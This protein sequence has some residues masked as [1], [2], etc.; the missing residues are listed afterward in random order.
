MTENNQKKFPK[1]DSLDRLI[2]FFDEN[3]LGDY[4]EQMPETD[5][6]V[7][8]QKRSYFVALDAEIADK[9]SEISKLEHLSS[10]K[11]VNSWLREKISSYSEKI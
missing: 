7:N 10:E 8:L 5:F 3:D 6:E 4:L 2:D 11:I 9:L 1:F